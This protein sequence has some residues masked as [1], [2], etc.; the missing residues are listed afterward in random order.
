MRKEKIRTKILLRN[1][2]KVYCNEE[3]REYKFEMNA[4]NKLHVNNKGE[5]DDLSVNSIL[6][7]LI[8]TEYLDNVDKFVLLF[9]HQ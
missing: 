7:K 4:Y 8:K 1:H 5:T 2:G 9:L 3:I 6:F